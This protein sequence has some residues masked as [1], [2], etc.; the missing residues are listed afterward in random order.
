VEY[1]FAKKEVLMIKLWLTEL[2]THYLERI[3][4]A[5]KNKILLFEKN[6]ITFYL[7]SASY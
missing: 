7:F 1:V 6:L 4:C 3:R 2:T 5:L